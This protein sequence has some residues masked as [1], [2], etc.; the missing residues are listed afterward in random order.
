MIDSYRGLAEKIK[1][2]DRLKL[3]VEENRTLANQRIR[4]LNETIRALGTVTINASQRGIVDRLEIA[5]AEESARTD[6]LHRQLQAMEADIIEGMQHLLA[7]ALQREENARQQLAAIRAGLD[8]LGRR[9]QSTND[10][11]V[12][13]GGRLDDLGRRLQTT[14]DTVKSY[15]GRLDGLDGRL[16]GVGDTVNYLI[17]VVNPLRK[18]MAENTAAVQNIRASN[19]SAARVLPARVIEAGGADELPPAEEAATLPDKLIAVMFASNPKDEKPVPLDVE[20]NEIQNQLAASQLGHLVQFEICPATRVTDL[21]DRL[22]RFSPRLVHFSGHGT[23][24]GIVLSTPKNLPNPVAPRDLIGVIRAT[25]EVPPVILFNICDS[26][27]FARQAAEHAEV[28]IGMA[29]KIADTAARTFTVRFYGGIASG[30]SVQ[31]SFAQAV[32]ALRAGGFP[33]AGYP[34]LYFRPDVD[35]ARIWLVRPSK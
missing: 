28:A 1:T 13:H 35:P 3:R 30:K 26:A 23:Q 19:A 24:D 21:F 10:T 34:Q 18:V 20:M 6:A 9:L 29:G 31:A 2:R 22:N 15:G 8:D 12:S 16:N 5:A 33:D 14:N 11:L 17:R 27:D 25:L 4:K 32:E 7:A